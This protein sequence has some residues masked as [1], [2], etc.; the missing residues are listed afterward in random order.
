MLGQVATLRDRVTTI[1]DL[2]HDISA[3][4]T[5]FLETEPGPT[6]TAL[7]TADARP[8]DIAIVGMS[9]IFPGAADL[10]TFWENTLRGVDAITEVPPDR[11]DWRPYYDPDPKAPDRITSK[12]GG[13]LPDIPFDPLRYGMPPTSLPSI[14]PVQLLVLEAVRAAL[15]DAGYAERAFPRERTAVVLGMGGGAAQLAMGHAFRSYLPMLESLDPEVGRS[16]RAQAESLL[17]EWTEDSFPGF[18]LNVT[19]G[20]VANRFDLGGRELHR[21][22]RL[23]LVAGG[24]LPGRS[25]AGDRRRRHGHPGRGRHGPEPIHL[26]GL[27]QDPRLLAARAVPAVRRVGRRH[28]HQRGRGRRRAEA[29]GGR[30][31]RRRPDLRRHQGGRQLQRR[32]GPR[33]DR[34]ERRGA[35]PRPGPRLR[36]GGRRPGERRLRRGPR[37]RHGGRRRGRGQRPLGV[38]AGGR[39][40][41]GLVRRRLD[42]VDDR[43]HQVRRRAGRA[44]QRVPGPPSPDLAADHRGRAAQPEGR[45]RATARSRSAPRRGPGCTPAKRPAA[46][47]VS[48]FGFGGTNFH[49]VLEAYEGDLAPRLAPVRNWP[50][51]LLVWQADDRDELLG[52]LDRLA[53]QLDAGARP[54]LRDLAHTLAGRFD[55]DA[56][57]RPDAGRRRHDARRPA[58]EARDGPRR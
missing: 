4:G 11:W 33:P 19:A 39:G 49:A 42:Q 22:C 26:S 14:E 28:R 17:P 55:P 21:R 43:P 34:P 5:T 35:G 54:R 25:R 20:R 7:P 50:A 24:R 1:A 46:R 58:G 23:R 32:P 57:D 13:F 3:G 45:P 37:H 30:R 29:A 56:P 52:R 10:R 6:A 40:G 2:H 36:E 15:G 18:L 51:E 41:A 9:A 12:W 48:A 38:P 44:D 8:S 16:A 53:A 31:A 27:Q 47:G